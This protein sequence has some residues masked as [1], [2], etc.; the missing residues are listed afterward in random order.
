[1]KLVFFCL[2]ALSKAAD[3]PLLKD[4]QVHVTKNVKP[5]PKCMKGLCHLI[6]SANIMQK[7][8]AISVTTFHSYQ[9]L[10]VF[11]YF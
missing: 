9:L 5:E 4:I 2:R 10:C 11:I 8:D 6:L 3:A 1:M 7:L